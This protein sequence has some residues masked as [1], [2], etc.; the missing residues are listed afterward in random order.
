MTMTNHDV[1]YWN[2][3]LLVIPPAILV[4]A[5][6]HFMSLGRK[7]RRKALWQSGFLCTFL[8]AIALLIQLITTFHQGNA[9]YYISILPFYAAELVSARSWFRR[10]HR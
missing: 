4:S 10:I 3:N 1:T 8:M 2:I 6:L 7:E 9:A 5:I